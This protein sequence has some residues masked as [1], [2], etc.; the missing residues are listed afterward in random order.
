[1]NM[2]DK[3][4]QHFTLHEFMW[5]DVAQRHAEFED[6]VM[7][8]Q[9]LAIRA[10]SEQLEV[11]R[12]WYPGLRVFINSGMRDATIQEALLDAGVRS[13]TRSDHSFMSSWWPFGTGAVDFSVEDTPMATVM[14]DCTANLDLEAYGELIY[15]EDQNFIHMSNHAR[16]L[17]HARP[18]RDRWRIHD[19]AGFRRYA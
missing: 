18:Q 8:A 2:S 9:L 4:T 17:G 16:V 6:R 5:S 1:M 13:W 7:R 12:A 3:V 15:Y 14:R 11:V 19:K 10:L